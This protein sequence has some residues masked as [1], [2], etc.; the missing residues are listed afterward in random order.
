ML[1]VAAALLVSGCHSYTAISNRN[2]A[3]LYM[4]DDDGLH[5]DF[6]VVNVHDSL[7]RLYFKISSEQLLYISENGRDFKSL[8]KLS[9]AL[10]PGTD[11]KEVNDS[12]SVFL[13][14]VK[15]DEK[16][17]KIVSGHIDIDALAPRS[18][19]V[20]ITFRDINKKQQV[21]LFLPLDKSSKQVAQNFMVTGNDPA[22][23]LFRDEIDSGEVVHVRYNDSTQQ[24]LIVC[25]YNRQFALP[26]P[27]FS[28]DI[29]TNYNFRPDSV[30]TVAN[31]EA[32]RIRK[33][34]L[35]RFNTD[36]V[37][38]G[39]RTLTHFYNGYPEVNNAEMLLS[40]LRY[41]TSKNEY[42]DLVKAADTKK[43]VDA[44]WLDKAGSEVRGR[45]LIRKFYKRVEASNQL[46]TAHTEG[47]KTDRG[48]V[49]LIFGPPGHVYKT[50]NTE[51]WI[52][53]VDSPTNS[54]QFIFHRVTD[55]PFT[56][57]DYL[58]ERGQTFQPA[59]YHAVDA[60]RSGRVYSDR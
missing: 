1:F 6:E 55:N 56:G 7:S 57:N 34:G 49:Y 43:A 38:G 26:P 37:S 25:Y 29:K 35:Y 60:W 46:F 52:Y 12:S 50:L 51:T 5:P 40:P 17:N 8:I 22:L 53:G 11:S 13:S 18:Y 21:K 23:P 44:F 19:I 14:D 59:W 42:S 16:E 4:P 15:K 10:R 20:E 33:A 58:L 27:P 24:R 3:D 32:L 9:F 48:M 45:E 54:L 41:L 30:F 28:S 36:T 47:W 2:I 31:G 39:G